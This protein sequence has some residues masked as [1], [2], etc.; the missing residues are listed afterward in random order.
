[1][2]SNNTFISFINSLAN[3]GIQYVVLG[4][5]ASAFYGHIQPVSKIDL[6]LA[7]QKENV[8]KL[9]SLIQTD[10]DKY[11]FTAFQSIYREPHTDESLLIAF[12]FK[13]HAFEASDFDL[14]YARRE[15][16]AINNTIIP[17][18]NL[19]D[20][21]TEKIAS[22]DPKEEVAIRVLQNAQNIRQSL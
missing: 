4:G 15:K 17:I 10:S 7:S 11:S 1:M 6:W 13:L 9:N 12:S 5:V 18:L 14:C 2:V 19:D 21:L 20:L 22:G 16:A 3:A 8:E